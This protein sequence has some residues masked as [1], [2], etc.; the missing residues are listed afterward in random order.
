MQDLIKV[1][2]HLAKLGG[3]RDSDSGDIVVLVCDVIS[4][5]HVIEGSSEFIGRDPSR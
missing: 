1:S 3:H 5:D 4:L 2:Y